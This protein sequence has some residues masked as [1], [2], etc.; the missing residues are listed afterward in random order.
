M[1]RTP[2]TRKTPLKRSGMNRG[3]VRSPSVMWLKETAVVGHTTYFPGWVDVEV[4]PELKPYCVKEKPRKPLRKVNPQRQAK[5]LQAY[6]KVMASD[7]HKQLRYA[8][9]LRSGGLC[10][11]ERCVAIRKRN[12]T[13]FGIPE[14]AWIKPAGGMWASDE[15]TA[16]SEIPVWFTKRGG[17]PWQRFRSKDGDT[18]HTSYKH[19][20]DENPDE[21]RLVQWVWRDCHKRIESEH[22]TRRRYLATGK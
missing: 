14:G 8:A 22:N 18:H 9:F 13:A 2:L 5:R 20:G 12:T 1:K 19:F 3:K 10:E 6:R 16:H 17:E 4:F 7:F 11:C 21:L 15:V